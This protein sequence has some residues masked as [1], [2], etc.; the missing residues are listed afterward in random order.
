M[1]WENNFSKTVL[2]RGYNYY[3][4]GYVEDIYRTTKKIKAVVYGTHHYHVEI[5]LN[6]DCVEDMSCD[7][8]YAQ[9]G[10]NCKHMAAVLFEWERRVSHPEIDNSE[11]IDDASDD[12]IRAFLLGLFNENPELVERFNQFISK[13]NSM[14]TM[15]SELFAI[16]NHYQYSYNYIDTDHTVPFCEDYEK[17]VFKWFDLLKQKEEYFKAIRFFIEAHDI[18]GSL[19]IDVDE[20]Q[21]YDLSYYMNEAFSDILPYMDISERKEAFD[22]LRQ[23]FYTMKNPT[24]KIDIVETLLC[25]F[26]GDEYAKSQLDFVEEQYD[27]FGDYPSIF[28]REYMVGFFVDNYLELLEK[29]NAS[30]KEK[31]AVYKKYWK[32]GSVR[33]SCVQSYINDKEYDQALK[34]L[35]KCI[36]LDYKDQSLLKRDIEMK[37]DIYQKQ[38]NREGYREM[39]KALV[40]DFRDTGIEE[41]IEL[42]NLYTSEEWVKE[43]DSII[44]QI[45][46]DWF[47][48]AIYAEE[49]LHKQLLDSII[50]SNDK[51]LLK[52]YT[53]VL[54]DEYPEQLLH[55]Y[56]VA[57]EKEAE[58]ARNRSYYRQ[59]VE[60]LRNMKAITG[61]DKVV[62]EIIKKWKVQYK[63]RTAMMDELSRI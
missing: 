60:D 8:P 42:K 12:D 22:L 40:L 18:L 10:H 33:M 48:C 53:C 7:C 52:Q 55:M 6:G 29:N 49:N 34:Y 31:K 19:D 35:D 43:R 44:K 1:E 5:T 26:G 2:N 54:K 30:K 58:R 41:Y 63:N 11:I 24:F 47:L 50:K 59:L 3:L 28:N 27:Y 51:S 38:G 20:G 57:A 4:D 62:D 21:P 23:H 15:K 39:M 25:R 45:N 37:K 56:R 61:G 36:K 17:C 32:Y 13:E 14:D 9:D 46:S 16:I